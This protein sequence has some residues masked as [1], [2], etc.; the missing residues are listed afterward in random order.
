[1]NIARRRNGVRQVRQFGM[2]S[3]A[4]EL[5]MGSGQCETGT[6]VFAEREAHR[7]K[8]ILVVASSAIRFAKGRAGKLSLVR[9]D[10]ASLAGCGSAGEVPDQDLGAH[11]IPRGGLLRVTLLAGNLLMC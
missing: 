8:V 4:S 5:L 2:A 10:M 9:I 3:V 7:P 11:G 6:G 1:M